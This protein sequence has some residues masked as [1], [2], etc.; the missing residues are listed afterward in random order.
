M[1]VNEVA[2]KGRG[3]DTELAHVMQGETLIPPGVLTPE[4]MAQLYAQMEAAGIDPASH[5]VGEGMSINPETGLPEFG[6]GKFFK[7]IARIAIPA[8]ASYFLPG[9]GSAIGGSILG[10]GAAGA[11]TLGGALLGAGTSL[12]TGGGLKGALIGGLTGGLAPNA[13]DIGSYLSKS[14]SGALTDFGNY[15]GLGDVYNSASGALSDLGKGADSLYQGSDL[16]TAFKSG[17]DALKSI[18]VGTSSEATQTPLLGGGASS[19][20]P[21]LENAANIPGFNTN[22]IG[23]ELLN[24]ANLPNAAATGATEVA[25]SPNY[26]TPIASA[27]LGSNAN[28]K[29]EKA[30]LAGQRAN[31]ALLQPYANGFSFTPGDLTQDPGYQFQLT[32]GTKAADRA[33]LARGGYF[34]GGAAKE[35]AQFNQG[36]ADN[37]YN[38]AFNRA[39]QGNQ[40]GLQGALANT[41]VNTDIGNIKANSATNTGNLF[42]GALGNLLGGNSYTNTGALQGGFDMQD[43][44]RKLGIGNSAYAG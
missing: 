23:P 37:T 20:G 34:S 31:Q 44:L 9:I 22:S 33:Q 36:L 40:A 6:F 41:G 18:G 10:A 12:A 39:L 15:T 21:Q 27:L 42:S 3:G 28:D 17:G 25:K 19:Y 8:A 2:A 32:E 35:L 29:A 11:S 1:N 43:F 4:L 38:G 5:T 30:L 16:Q 26:F 14:A 24:S 7:K 13:G